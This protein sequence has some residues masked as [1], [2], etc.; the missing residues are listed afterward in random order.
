MLD[1]QVSLSDIEFDIPDKLRPSSLRELGLKPHLDELIDKMPQ[2]KGATAQNLAIKALRA[3]RSIRPQRIGNRCVFEPSCS[4]YSELAFRT[5]P[6]LT[7]IHL[8]IR[9]LCR[10]RPGNGGTDLIDLEP[11]E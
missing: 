11:P 7:A 2:Q 4:R 10:C 5:K 8:T 3:Y 9:R 6:F 1:K